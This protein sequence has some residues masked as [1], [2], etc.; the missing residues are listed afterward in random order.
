[1]ERFKVK[2]VGTLQWTGDAWVSFLA[3]GTGE[4]RRFQ[5]CLNP[6]SSDTLLHFRAIQGHSGGNLVD[7]LLQDNV[8]LPDDFT[9]YIYHFG[10]AFEMHSIIKSGLIPGRKSLRRES[11]SVF[12]TAVNPMYASQDLEEVQYDLDKPRSTVYKITWRVHQNTVYWCNL[13]LAQRKGLQFY[14]TRSHAI[15][16]SSTLPSIYIEKVVCM[17][18]LKNYLQGTSV[19]QTTSCY[20]CAELATPS[21]GSTCYRFVKIP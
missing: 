14:Q 21:E 11:Q 12:F 20:T 8:L 18:L 3:K 17:K 15:T 7:P 9:E 10:N 4:K 1:M 16:L 13:K 6:Y 5:Y 19:T 2:F